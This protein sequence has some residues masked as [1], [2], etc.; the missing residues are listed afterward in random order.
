MVIGLTGKKDGR[1]ENKRRETRWGAARDE[2]RYG[3]RGI[4]SILLIT[5]PVRKCFPGS[6]VK[7]TV[8]RKKVSLDLR[9]N[10]FVQS[11]PKNTRFR[12]ALAQ[13]SGIKLKSIQPTAV[14]SCG[15]SKRFESRALHIKKSNVYRIQGPP[16]AMAHPIVQPGT[17]SREAWATVRLARL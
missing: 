7:L 1:D 13:F 14:P 2:V 12:D 15:S 11:N 9:P 16:T 8:H 10:L 5:S 3:A 17:V 6:A 4:D